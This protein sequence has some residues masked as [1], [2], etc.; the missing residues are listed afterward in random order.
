[1]SAEGGDNKSDGESGGKQAP[2]A[3]IEGE[4]LNQPLPANGGAPIELEGQPVPQQAALEMMMEM[5]ASSG[6]LTDPRSIREYEQACPGL[7]M[8]ILDQFFSQTAKEQDHRHAM[9]NKAMANEV[10][11]DKRLL[12]QGD[13]AQRMGLFVVCLGLSL[14]AFLFYK[15]QYAAGTT[16]LGIVLGSTVGSFIYGRKKQADEA[17]ANT[18]AEQQPPAASSVEQQTKSERPGRATPAPGKSTP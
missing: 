5:R 12:D 10:D 4:L 17:I 7:G 9:E 3:T 8:K 13:R 11:Q 1:M 16:A 14:V 2:L 15:Q 6:V 18:K